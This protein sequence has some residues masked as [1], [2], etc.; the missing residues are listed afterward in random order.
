MADE[1]CLTFNNLH[2]IPHVYVKKRM[3]GRTSNF[4]IPTSSAACLLFF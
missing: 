1:R 3:L 4:W 2:A